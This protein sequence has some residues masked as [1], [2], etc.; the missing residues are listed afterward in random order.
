MKFEDEL[1]EALG[2]ID[3]PEIWKEGL[4]NLKKAEDMANAFPTP[5]HR[6]FQD[7][8]KE[9]RRMQ[10]EIHRLRSKLSHYEVLDSWVDP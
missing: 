3:L 7:S 2:K 8:C 1:K 10:K 9:L 6:A 5:L 4:F